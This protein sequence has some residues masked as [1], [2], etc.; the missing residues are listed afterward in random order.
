MLVRSKLVYGC[1]VYGSARQSVLRQLDPIRHQG[2]RWGLS[3]QSL[4]VEAHEPSLASRRL[5]LALN[6]VIKLKSPQEN[7]AYRSENVK[8]S[9]GSPSK[10]PPHGIRMLPHLDKSKVNLDLIDGASF[11]DIAPWTLSDPTVLFKVT[12]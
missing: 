3:A 2:L 10:C 1:V 11:L 8:P 4:Y 9:E 5:K 6:Y 12:K 7:P